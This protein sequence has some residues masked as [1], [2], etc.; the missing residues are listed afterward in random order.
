MMPKPQQ[1]P[2]CPNFGSGP[3]AKPPSWQLDHLQSALVGRS[4]RSLEGKA[5]LAQLIEKTRSILKVP[6]GY[7]IGIMPGSATG[8]IECA[9]WSCLGLYGVDVMA[10]DVFGK[11]W[12]TDVIEQLKLTDVNV[13]QADY[14]QLPP[15]VHNPDRDLV[16]TWN[17]TTS[18]TCVPNAD[19][20]HDDRKGLTICDATSAAFCFD[21]PWSKLDITAYAW[22]KG[23]GSEAAHGM[24]ILSPQAVD[25]LQTYRPPWPLPRL[26]RLTNQG[27]L[28][29]GIF[30]GETINTPSMLCAEDCLLSLDW[31]Q[32]IG[33]MEGLVNR[34][35]ANFGVLKEWVNKTSWVDFMAHDPSITSPISVCLTLPLL[36]DHPI[37]AQRE[38]LKSFG[39][40]LRNEQA[41]FEIVNHIHA[42]PSLRIWCGPTVESENIELL[43]P[44]LEWSY[45]ETLIEFGKL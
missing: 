26:F 9:L 22:Q 1:K 13:M 17:G 5:K 2:I 39:A 3:T 29:E 8:A 15:L 35:Q 16:F 10:F 7:R 41:A 18:G 28:T 32:Q 4:H 30:R 21:L 36:K 40:L 44:W 24:L 37:V 45:Q 20:I 12:V 34:C 11:L 23:L 38:F 27:N 14:G 31:A 19:W 33:G 43:L 42:P 6:E 25:R